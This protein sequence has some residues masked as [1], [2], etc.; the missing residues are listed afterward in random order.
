MS[1]EQYHIYLLYPGSCELILEL[2]HSKVI[3][4]GGF[5]WLTTV[6]KGEIWKKLRFIHI[7]PKYFF[8]E[9]NEINQS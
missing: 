2:F 7:S 4:P 6:G 9:T 1:V 8:F 3:L 5:G